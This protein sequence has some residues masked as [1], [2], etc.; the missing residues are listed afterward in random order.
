MSLIHLQSM[1]EDVLRLFTV[2]QRILVHTVSVVTMRHDGSAWH[3]LAGGTG[4]IVETQHNRF[5]ATASHV[6]LPKRDINSVLSI[7][8]HAAKFKDI[9]DWRI[10]ASDD[11]LD[12]ATIQPDP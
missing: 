8:G 10:I 2:E 9:S 11:R 7:G 1:N 6:L 4:C 3:I 5:I 12:I